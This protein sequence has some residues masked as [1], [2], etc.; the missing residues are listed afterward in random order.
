MAAGCVAALALLLY[1]GCEHSGVPAQSSSASAEDAFVA[2]S[3]Q[4]VEISGKEWTPFGQFFRPITS[5]D[6]NW[7]SGPT[8]IRTVSGQ[9]A[10]LNAQAMLDSTRLFALQ[11]Q[12]TELLAQSYT[13]TS[14][15]GKPSLAGLIT[16]RIPATNKSQEEFRTNVVGISLDQSS[17]TPEIVTSTRV[18]S[19]GQHDIALAATSDQ[20]VV[21]LQFGGGVEQG[22]ELPPQLIGIDAVRGT[23]IW[24]VPDEYSVAFGENEAV[25][26]SVTADA[27]CPDS[28][29]VYDVATGATIEERPPNESELA[30]CSQ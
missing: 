19:G 18:V 1:S 10:K 25:A 22:A 7:L 2:T 16:R 15:D 23:K 5:G 14:S 6:E 8:V 11:E 21:V 30:H 24:N 28:V 26:A 13:Y 9:E 17:G 3:P 12:D 4:N 20:G 29:R 27:T